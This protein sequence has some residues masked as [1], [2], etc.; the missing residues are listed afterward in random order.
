MEINN[1][2]FKGILTLIAVLVVAGYSLVFYLK[3]DE[4]VFFQH[5]YDQRVYVDREH[6]QDISFNLGYITN[7]YDNSVV[8]DIAFPEYPEITI[9]ASEYGYS[10]PFNWGSEQNKTP[11]DIYGRYNVRS[12]NC[13]IIDLPKEKDLDGIVLTQAR[14]LF[15]D[16]SEMTVD[17]GEIHLYE[18]RFGKSPLE[19]V[20]S[21]GSNNGTGKTSYRILGDLTI[22]AIDSPLMEKFK[23]RVQWK[24]NGSNPEDSL[25]MTLQ[26]GN[27]L[28][29]TT[30]VGI[31]D[32]IVS[33]YTLFDIH[34]KLTITDDDGIHYYERVYNIKSLYHNY[35]FMGLYRYIKAREAI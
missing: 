11:G 33:Q 21:S 1:R 14:I 16:S 13:K 18:H 9:Q 24:I 20:S 28:D 32:D 8:I 2:I 15:S 34:P 23:D 6:Y 7:A 10:H 29:V 17:I 27:F 25:G 22:T 4:P 5:Y 12:V 31:G 19:H 3:L 30:K 35:S 26:K